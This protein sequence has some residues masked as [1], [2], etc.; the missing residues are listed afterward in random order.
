MPFSLTHKVCSYLMV[1]AAL[2]SVVLSGG[3]PL[4]ATLLVFGSIA[5]SWFA[6]PPR[7]RVERYTMAWNIAALLFLAY[8]IVRVVQGG[9]VILAGLSFLVFVLINKLFSRRTSRDYQQAYV[10]SFLML[11]AATT[12]DTGLAYAVCFALYVIFAV[13]S[14]TLFHLR[15][16]MEENYLLKHSG[17]GEQSEKVEVERIL[18][19]RRIVGA[20][21]LAGTSV[22]SL[23]MLLAAALVFA[24]FPR[25]GFGLFAGPKRPGIAAVGFSDQVQLGHHGAIRDDQRVVMRVELGAPGKRELPPVTLRW[26]GSAFDRYDRGTWRHSAEVA[27]RATVVTPREGLYVL[28]RVAGASDLLAPQSIR[29]ETLRQQIYLEPLESSVV[30]AA[31][32]PVAVE[33]PPRKIGRQQP[34]V[35]R[36]G[37]LG[38][39]R[40]ANRRTVGAHYVAYSKLVAPEQDRLRAARPLVSKRFARYLQLPP[41]LP[42]RVRELAF[43]ITRGKESPYEKVLALE[44]YLQR[45]YTYTLELTH[46][47][48]REPVDEFLFETRRGHCEYFASALALLLRVVGV[49]TRHVNGFVNGQWN[50]YGQYLAVRQADA[51]A[52]TEVLFPRVGWVAF[53][54]TPP[55]GVPAARA[56]GLLQRVNQLLDAL[57][58]RWFTYV[59]EYDLSKQ[60]A[61][62]ERARLAL[63]GRNRAQPAVGVKG[64][65][66]AHRRLVYG[67]GG[68]AVVVTLLVLLRRRLRRAA[69]STGGQVRAPVHPATRLYLK[70]LRT[71]DKTSSVPLVSR[72]LGA[73]NRLDHQTPAEFARQLLASR[74]PS[75]TLVASITQH[76]YA[77]RFDPAADV[78]S[79]LAEMAAQ[80]SALRRALRLK[81]GMSNMG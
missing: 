76:Y 58:M 28:N 65:I 38:E 31:D 30:F 60:I 70:M 39:I 67:L 57:R 52:W 24:L 71:V 64:W 9:E 29:A 6:E 50:E 69:S 72:G 51:H 68:L 48:G 46:E 19:S 62:V 25:I 11:V 43:E 77:A 17:A 23:A 18:H 49:H 75:A 74:D 14:L 21:F 16:E 41:D 40:A 10:I 56:G 36:R 26:R 8:L 3:L 37:P 80:L 45:N 47:S 35:P 27:G 61:L 22:L 20:G 34:F 2:A 4:V 13:W 7:Y 81:R 66:A 53:D 73:C 33:L 12:L 78:A 44:S 5:L 55:Q 59:V 54:A 42:A 79:N 15:R 1:L 32:R 63:R